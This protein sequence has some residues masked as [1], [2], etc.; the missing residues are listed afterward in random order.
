MMRRARTVS[1][2]C[3]SAHATYHLSI[4]LAQNHYNAHET[5]TVPNNVE[6]QMHAI[7]ASKSDATLIRS[8]WCPQLSMAELNCARLEDRGILRRSEMLVVVA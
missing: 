1:I 2:R 7:C 4:Q 3:A 8:M 5:G 6:Y